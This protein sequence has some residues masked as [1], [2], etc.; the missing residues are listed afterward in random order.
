MIRSMVALIMENQGA[1]ENA[2]PSMEIPANQKHI[3]GKG[4]IKLIEKAFLVALTDRKEPVEIK[5]LSREIENKMVN[6]VESLRQLGMSY[7]W[8]G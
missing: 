6:G 1:E 7:S 8:L 2:F 4:V 3:H 5:H